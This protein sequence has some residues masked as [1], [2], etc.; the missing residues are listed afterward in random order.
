MGNSSSTSKTAETRVDGG[1]LTPRGIYTGPHDWNQHTVGHL[2]LE[3]RLAPFYRPLE[4]YDESW[5]DETILA[6]RRGPDTDADQ[7]AHDA[8]KHGKSQQRSSREPPR[9]SD[10]QIYKGAIECPICFMYYPPNINHSRCCFQAICTE[11]F[12]QIKRNEPT[13][14]HLVSEPACCPY[15]QQENFGVTYTPPPWRT[16]LSPDSHMTRPDMHKSASTQSESS[17]RKSLSH[18]NPNV[19]TIDQIRPDWEERL[20]AVKAAVARRANRRIIMRQVGDR[21]IPVGVT[22]SRTQLPEGITTVEDIEELMLMEAMRLSLL[23]QERAN[24]QASNNPPSDS[25]LARD[26]GRNRQSQGGPALSALATPL[27]NASNLVAV[28]T[29]MPG[30]TLPEAAGSPA[31]NPIR[32]PSPHVRTHSNPPPTTTLAAA[33]SA[34]STASAVLQSSETDTGVTSPPSSNGEPT[35]ETPPARSEAGGTTLIHEDVESNHG[36]PST[37]VSPPEE[38]A[39]VKANTQQLEYVKPSEE[40][41]TSTR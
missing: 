2:I 1:F 26:G 32:S 7:H 36:G 21:L 20:A 8:H 39:G 15:C 33:L 41:V 13:P 30:Q 19:V 4:D 12:V 24:N 10:A 17:R 38:H 14:T 29:A 22:S 18:D 28:S 11:C 6:N 25:R 23:D 9:P 40:N 3:R 5:D 35:V 37:I 16:G 34:S 27:V 31:P